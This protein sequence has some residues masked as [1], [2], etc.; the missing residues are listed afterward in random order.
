[1][2]SEVG[3]QRIQRRSARRLE[4][5]GLVEIYEDAFGIYASPTDAGRARE[6][7]ELGI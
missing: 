2:F 4:E 7:L 1:M 5:L 6:T 3:T